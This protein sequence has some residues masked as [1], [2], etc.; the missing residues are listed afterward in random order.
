MRLMLAYRNEMTMLLGASVEC[1]CSSLGVLIP[2][3]IDVN[4][5][6]GSHGA[7]ESHQA[8]DTLALVD[9]VKSTADCEQTNQ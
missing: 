4:S 2:L 5:G 3:A 9:Q 6:E 7:Q 8:D 1:L